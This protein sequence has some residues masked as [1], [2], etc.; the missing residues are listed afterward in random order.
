MS[1]IE[2]ADV[3]IPKHTKRERYLE[4]VKKA[5]KHW[6][7]CYSGDIPGSPRKETSAWSAEDEKQWINKA[8]GILNSSEATLK[9]RVFAKWLLKIV[10]KNCIRRQKN[11]GIFRNTR[12]RPKS[13][14][15]WWSDRAREAKKQKIADRMDYQEKEF[16]ENIVSNEAC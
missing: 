9:Q 11:F 6:Q 12:N 14:D 15:R 3:K 8:E 2:E 4:G 1:E 10:E 16:I 13:N 7:I 5:K